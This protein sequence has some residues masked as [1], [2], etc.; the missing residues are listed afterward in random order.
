[1]SKRRKKDFTDGEIARMWELINGK[2]SGIK[3]SISQV[4]KYFGTNKPSICKALN[5]WNTEEKD[6]ENGAKGKF[7]RGK[8]IVSYYEKSKEEGEQTDANRA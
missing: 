6:L 3:H 5:V 7:T 1:M 2:P 4:A 8:Y